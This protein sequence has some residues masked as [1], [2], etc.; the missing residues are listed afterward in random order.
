M[1]RKYKKMQTSAYSVNT[2]NTP[3]LI[4]VE[5]P[6]KCEKIEKFLGFQ[7][8]CISS[9]GHI[10]YL[11]KVGSIKT[12][13]APFYEIEEEK[14]THVDFMQKMIHQFDPANIFL[15]TD[16]DRE[17]EA[18]AWH[19]CQVFS[20]N[21]S[22]TKRIIFHE[23]TKEAL[24]KSVENPIFLR[25]NIVKAQ[26]TRQIL[27]RIIG[28]KI[29]PFLTK[30]LAHDNTDFLTAG[31]CQTPALRLVFDN[32]ILNQHKASTQLEYEVTG[33]FFSHPST[34]KIKLRE[35]I[36]SE[37]TCLE[38]LELSKSYAHILSVHKSMKKIKNAPLPFNT[39]SLLQS[40]SSYANCSPKQ[41]MSYCQELYQDGHITYM[42]TDS[43]KLAKP[44]LQKMEDFL[45][46]TYGQQYC[47]NQDLLE[48]K[49]SDPHEAI[50]ITDISTTQVE[51]D[52]KKKAIYKLIFVR[53]F[54]SCMSSF[55]Y[56]STVIHISAPLNNHYEHDI[57]I[58]ISLG[59]K[60]LKITEKEFAETQQQM[61]SLYAYVKN[62]EQKKIQYSKIDCTVVN[63]NNRLHF[64][65]AGL[66]Q[67]L[68]DLGIGRPSTFSTLIE[69]IQT[70]KYVIKTDME[71]HSHMCSEYSL[72]KFHHLSSVSVQKTFGA[73]KNKLLIDNLGKQVMSV[74]LDHF[75]ALFAYDYTKQMEEALD[76]LVQNSEKNGFDIISKCEQQIKECMKPLQEKMK[77]AYKID[78]N[79]FV[80]FGKNGAYIKY[81][82]ST[83]T[84]SI[85]PNIEIDFEKLKNN[86][87]SL[88][89]L[90]DESLGVYENEPLFLKKG[91]YGPYAQW[92]SNIKNLK[93]ICTKSK[94]IETLSFDQICA[95]LTAVNTSSVLR[96]IG[97]H[98]NIQNGKYGPYI[99]YKT[100]E[101]KKPQF[102]PLKSFRMGYMTCE[103]STLSE[104]LKTHHNVTL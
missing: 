86:L 92:G 50:R 30:L 101:M 52:V 2:L 44:F 64:T 39:S 4:I 65:E 38:F 57:E 15:A 100:E 96:Q 16:D 93:S 7:Y 51:G 83:K 32:C 46:K 31:R 88:D 95:Y 104:W 66:I 76:E 12:Q 78:D 102:F 48:N 53:T 81:A 55:E 87:Y 77:E 26:Q 10:R 45:S 79:S 73:E 71:G 27:D 89:E 59:W 19:I 97:P 33:S 9:K 58:G 82:N 21:T 90:K 17:G 22:T 36:N 28:F 49:S 43:T 35:N 72:D 3:F 41:T 29:S 74:L 6:S 67:K 84:S 68:E 75:S 80:V 37:P 70:R 63:T 14:R 91:K 94:S 85:K 13:Y 25:M 40:A 98:A 47:G 20:L 5:S 69:T 56:S 103:I 62:L 11:E 60:R 1:Q 18:I 42:R 24:M 23:M 54:E 34:L 8:K 61:N 99:Y